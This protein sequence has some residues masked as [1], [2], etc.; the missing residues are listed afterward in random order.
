MKTNARRMSL[1]M[2]AAAAVAL[3]MSIL[4]ACSGDDSSEDLIG[5]NEDIGSTS[6]GVAGTIAV[7][8]T[9]KSTT[10][11]NLRTG[12][13]TSYKI[14]HV[15]PSGAKVT[16]EAKDPKNGFYKIKHD[17]TVGW[18]SGKYYTTVSSGGGGGGGSLSA[19]RQEAI[20]RGKSMKGFSYWWGHGR[21]RPE[22]PT[23]STKGSCS[24]SCP[25]CSHSGSYGADC[26]GFVAKAWSIPSSNADITKDGHPY[27]TI[28]FVGSS[29]NWSTVSRGSVKPAD[30]LVYNTNGAG[31]IILYS[32]GD[33]WGSMYAYECKGCSAGC[34][35]GL[36][37]A[38]SSY[39]AIRRAGW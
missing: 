3:G 27:G 16:V 13:G 14:L 6:E 7:G 36:R 34:V 38:S 35:Y 5:A 12:P 9:L 8:T 26:S 21:W 32:G 25:S 4:P 15:V 17:G 24:G 39:K 22:G 37:T 28:H 30:A 10:N 1:S 2:A 29:S 18:S 31:H 23:A 19:A 11:V 20:N 33:G